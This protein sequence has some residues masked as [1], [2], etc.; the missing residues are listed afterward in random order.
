LFYVS[1]G[2]LCYAKV[3]FAMLF[4]GTPKNSSFFGFA[5]QTRP[6]PLSRV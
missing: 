4:K 5:I 3:F 1:A 2:N 6:S